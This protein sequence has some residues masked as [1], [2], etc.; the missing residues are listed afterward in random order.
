M[1]AMRAKIKPD[2]ASRLVSLVRGFR[3]GRL[4]IPDRPQRDPAPSSPV[5]PP[6]DTVRGAGALPSRGAREPSGDSE[7]SRREVAATVFRQSCRKC[8]GDDGKGEPMRGLIP[9]IPG[10][11]NI[12][13]QGGVS[14][15]QLSASILEGKN[16]HMPAFRA[17]LGSVRVDELVAYIRS[18]APSRRDPIG[19]Q[20][21]DFERRFA[22]LR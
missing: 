6:T 3:G 20:P 14:K 19:H 1:P 10:F 5:V 12:S 4:V 13:W 21:E 16:T 2:D 11:T 8:H 22:E 9:G 15:A 18:F 7:A 17:R